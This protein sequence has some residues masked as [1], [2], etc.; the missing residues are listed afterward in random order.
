M[1]LSSPFE[2]VYERMGAAFA[3]YDGWRLPKDF[4]DPAAERAALENSSAAFDLSSFGRIAVKGPGIENLMGALLC[5]SH[6]RAAD[7]QW[8]WTAAAADLTLL[9]IGS[10]KGGCLVLTPPSQRLDLLKNMQ[11]LAAS[12]QLAEVSIADLTEKTGMMGIYGPN[13]FEAVTR[14]LPFDLSG[15]KAGGVRVMSFFMINI[16]IL[17]GAWTGGDGVELICPAS[18]ANLAAG[19]IAK[20]RQ[21]ENIV[22]AGMDCLMAAVRKT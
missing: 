15:I 22:P 10:V 12:M 21:R 13:A 4:G 8:C 3:D 18:A 1:A 20:Y 7:E 6:E 16:T 9:R 5:Q 17:R 2:G 14:I 19:A 11:A